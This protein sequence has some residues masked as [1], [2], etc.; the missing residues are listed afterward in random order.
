M[1]EHG[2]KLLVVELVVA[3]DVV[4]SDKFFDLG[5]GNLLAQLLKRVVQVVLRDVPAVVRVELLENGAQPRVAQESL[6]VDSRAD[7]LRVVDLAVARV[8]HLRDHLL[9]L[10]AAHVHLPLLKNVG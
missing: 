3:L 10:L 5:P 8:V 7:E 4:L 1:V 9:D 6:H 2:S